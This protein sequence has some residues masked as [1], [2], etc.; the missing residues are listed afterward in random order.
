M[1]NK[2]Y[3]IELSDQ[4]EIDFYK[5]YEYYADENLKV[6]DSFYKQ[7]NLSL[8]SLKQHR[9]LSPKFIKM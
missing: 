7:I 8:D 5:A 4:S 3:I 9:F 2:Q 6:A 1:K